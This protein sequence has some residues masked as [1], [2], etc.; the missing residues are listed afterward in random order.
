MADLSPR[1]GAPASSP[2]PVTELLALCAAD[3]QAAAP[4][5]T[6]DHRDD[7]HLVPYTPAPVT[8]HASRQA[9]P[10]PTDLQVAIR[11]AQQLLDSDQVLSLREA[12]RLLLRA[13]GAEPVDEDMCPACD[14][15]SIERCVACGSC[16]CDRHD[17]CVR[18]EPGERP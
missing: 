5:R 1:P 4:Q 10:E 18:P 13:L 11:V 12:L 6:A 2:T 9:V 17:D 3:Y 15:T 14:T 8:G 16:R 7:T